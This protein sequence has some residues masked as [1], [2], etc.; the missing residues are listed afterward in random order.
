VSDRYEGALGLTLRNI[1]ISVF[2]DPE[3][4]R[5]PQ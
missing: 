1:L 3:R 4:E 2:G 5:S